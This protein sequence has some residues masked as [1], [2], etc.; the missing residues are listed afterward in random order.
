[1]SIIRCFNCEHQ[2]DSDFVEFTEY[3]GEQWCLDCHGEHMDS[4]EETAKKLYGNPYD[5]KKADEFYSDFELSTMSLIDNP[6]GA[7]GAK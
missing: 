2:L 6:K 7:R 4:L 5:K 3:G 1:M